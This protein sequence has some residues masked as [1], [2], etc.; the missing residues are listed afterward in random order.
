MIDPAL[1]AAISA[2]QRVIDRGERPMFTIT[3]GDDADGALYVEVEDLPGVDT[4]AEDVASV[5]RRA[6]ERIAGWLERS[7]EAFDVRLVHGED[8]NEG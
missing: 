2:A 5:E 4:G 7:E 3:Y 6:R 8:L 1:A